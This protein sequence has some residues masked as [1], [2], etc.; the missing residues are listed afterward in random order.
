MVARF[1]EQKDHCTLLRALGRL[2]PREWTLEL[3]GD[4]PLMED[5]AELA[6]GV[7]IADRVQF[8]GA[9]HDVAQRLAE[10]QLFVLVSHWE[11]FPRSILEAMRAGLPVVTTRTGGAPESVEHGTTGAVVRAREVG[12]LAA[13]LEPLIASAALR[14]RMGDAGRRRYEAAFTFQRMLARTV[15]VYD[16]VLAA[17]A[18]RVGRPVFAPSPRAVVRADSPVS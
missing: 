10:A 4:G 7:G 8:L 18:R 1:E 17:R 9:R 5:A 16:Q 14:R 13:A 12:E 3:I 6:R 15:S 2:A 11:G